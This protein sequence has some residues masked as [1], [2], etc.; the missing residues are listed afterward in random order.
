[1]DNN[2]DLGKTEE[3]F[4]GRGQEVGVNLDDSKQKIIEFLTA[5]FSSLK[6]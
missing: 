4:E 1:M 3:V 6:W 5:I 2:R